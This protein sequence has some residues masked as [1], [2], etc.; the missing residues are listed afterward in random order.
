MR[1][2]DGRPGVLLDRDGVL[3]EDT[4]YVGSPKDLRLIPGAGRAI[5]RFHEAGIMVAVVTNQAG[6]ARGFFEEEDV[7]RTN[8]ALADLLTADGDAPDAFYFCP[9]HVEGQVS[10][11]A[12][13]CACRK[14][15]TGMVEDAIRDLSLDRSRTV[16]VGD[17]EKD[18][19]C[20]RA[21]RV[22]T[23]AVG[24]AADDLG[25]DHSAATLAEAAPWILARLEADRT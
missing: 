21:A 22:T 11:Y 15:K 18:I 14:P 1:A 25:A 6:V 2:P 3:D 10:A 23:V 19:E 24:S 8:E 7:I 13:E 20:G 16:M 4:G 5:A 17:S 9:H 12:I